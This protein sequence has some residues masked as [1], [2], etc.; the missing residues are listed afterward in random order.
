MNNFS[1]P[2]FDIPG[3]LDESKFSRFMKISVFHQFIAHTPALLPLSQYHS[4]FDFK[5]EILR[6]NHPDEK[7]MMPFENVN[8]VLI[9]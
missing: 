1:L 8:E 7:Q 2:K 4:N 3:D 6:R 9:K 5:D